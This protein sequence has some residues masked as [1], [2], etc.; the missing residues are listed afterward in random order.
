MTAIICAIA[1]SMTPAPQ[2]CQR[3]GRAHAD[4]SYE[5]GGRAVLVL[6]LEETGP[7]PVW[8]CIHRKE[9]AWDD[10]LDPYWGGLQ[11]DRGFMASYGADFIRAH[12]GQGWGG[13]G[14]ADSWTPREQMVAAWRAVVGY[15]RGDGRV[16]GPRG[17]GPWPHTRIGCA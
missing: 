7:V 5:R 11:E 13:L 8:V 6:A 12:R 9:G 1:I 3:G 16:F 15:V 4:P 10:A 2:G 14:L 17:Y